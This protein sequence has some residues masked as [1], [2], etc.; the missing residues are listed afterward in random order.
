V[1]VNQNHTFQISKEQLECQNQYGLAHKVRL[2]YIIH[3]QVFVLIDIAV[4]AW[5]DSSFREQQES[6]G[7]GR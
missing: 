7:Y 6:G 2:R 5:R 4:L 1:K 3:C